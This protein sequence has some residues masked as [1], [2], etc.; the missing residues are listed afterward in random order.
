M[1]KKKKKREPLGRTMR[2]YEGKI[3][4]YLNLLAPEFDI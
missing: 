2:G 1:E 4:R 3:K